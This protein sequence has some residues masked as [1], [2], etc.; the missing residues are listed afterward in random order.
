MRQA[1]NKVFIEG[2]LSENNLEVKEYNKKNADGT[3]KKAEAIMGTVTIKVPFEDKTV[4]TSSGKDVP[5]LSTVKPINDSAIFLS[6]PKILDTF[7]EMPLAPYTTNSPHIAIPTIQ[8]VI[9]K[10]GFN[11][12]TFSLLGSSL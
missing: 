8:E 4:V 7:N 1:E 12:V 9:N 11:S 5:T 6:I 2:I 10:I 3:T